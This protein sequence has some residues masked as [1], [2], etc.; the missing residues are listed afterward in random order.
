MGDR[1]VSLL[2]SGTEIVDALEL[3]DR[4]VGISHECDYPATL[5]DRPRVSR[6]RFDPEGLDSGAIDR[7]VRQAMAEHGSV[8]QVDAERLAGLRP[9]LI[10]TQ[11]V[12]AV[13]AVATPGV[14]ETVGRL[15][16]E[17]DVLSLDAHTLADILGTV[18]QVAAAAGV[19]G[20]GDAVAGELARRLGRV[21][22]AVEG[23]RRPRVLALEWLDPPFTPGHWVPEMIMA[24]GGE[25]L[26]GEAGERSMETAWEALAGL[27]PDV[28]LIMPCGY[29]LDASIRDADRHAAALAGVAPRATREGRAYVV[30]G[31]SYFNRSG[32]RAVDGVAI[33]AGLLHADRWP[34]P[35]GD[36][37]AVWR[38]S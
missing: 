38:P 3:G 26:A 5:L 2:A 4:L 35:S 21:R 25:C 29:G 28:L 9:S 15:G 14:R 17:A 8:Y 12:C 18:R 7:A 20:R 16:L 31:S 13:C 6:P 10:L 22:E 30:D 24:A 37:A 27:D 19:A 23:A 1:I 32:P 11:A 36:V 34:A 33:L